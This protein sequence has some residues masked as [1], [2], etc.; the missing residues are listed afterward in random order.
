MICG[1]NIPGTPFPIED[2]DERRARAARESLLLFR[3]RGRKRQLIAHVRLFGAPDL[4]AAAPIHD[5]A[6]AP[7][8]TPAD[9]RDLRT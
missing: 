6:E 5:F 1:R 8:D 2:S 7:L 9:G 3:S 4:A